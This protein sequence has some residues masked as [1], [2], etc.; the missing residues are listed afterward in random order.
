MK[1]A[2]GGTNLGGSDQAWRW[3]PLRRSGS[4]CRRVTQLL[5]LPV[6]G[7]EKVGVH[8][9]FL[10]LLVLLGRDASCLIVVSR[11]VRRGKF[12]LYHL[13]S[14]KGRG[15]YEHPEKKR[16]SNSI[17][18]LQFPFDE[19]L[20]V[21]SNCS[22]RKFQWMSL[23]CAGFCRTFI[24]EAE[25]SELREWRRRRF[26]QTLRRLFWGKPKKTCSKKMFSTHL[27][28]QGRFCFSQPTRVSLFSVQETGNGPLSSCSGPIWLIPEF[29][30]E[31]LKG[32][33]SWLAGCFAVCLFV[34]L[35][36]SFIRAA[37]S[38]G[39]GCWKL[40]TLLIFTVKVSDIFRRP[41]YLIHMHTRVTVCVHETHWHCR[42]TVS[43][44]WELKKKIYS[45]W[46]NFAG[47]VFDGR[48]SGP[49]EG[50]QLEFG[51]RIAS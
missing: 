17:F 22:L 49:V 39:A 34:W 4:V 47:F 45:L 36:L 44:Q 16:R 8:L 25:G 43:L 2:L 33:A 46:R 11:E 29:P 9:L 7:I 32:R 14:W 6:Y 35:L 28:R 19:R 12:L 10:L 5:R 18:G 50:R 24:Q 20:Q 21:Q 40:P 38:T 13:T 27:Q 15:C 37:A 41:V 23:T 42:H 1:S 51:G 30:A 31:R 48:R 3:S 26:M